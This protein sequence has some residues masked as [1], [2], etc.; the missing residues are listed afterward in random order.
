MI[1]GLDVLPSSVNN[2]ITSETPFENQVPEGTEVILCCSEGT[3]IKMRST[4]SGV[5]EWVA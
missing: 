2:I 1:T 4:G 5:I 3:V